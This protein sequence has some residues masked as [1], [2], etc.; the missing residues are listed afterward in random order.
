MAQ[1]ARRLGRIIIH[2]A[3]RNPLP[4]AFIQAT[5]SPRSKLPLLPLRD[6]QQTLALA[7]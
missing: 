6:G 5:T 3:A 4:C 2:Q 7:E 1:D